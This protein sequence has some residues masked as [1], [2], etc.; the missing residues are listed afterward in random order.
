[1]FD[2]ILRSCR[3]F[4]PME[5]FT[6][7]KWLLCLLLLGVLAGC[8]KNQVL[9]DRPASLDVSY[10]ESGVYAMTVGYE[11]H[12]KDG[13]DT[14]ST[15][16]PQTDPTT[17]PHFLPYL[18][19]GNDS[20]VVLTFS[21]QPDKLLVEHYSAA[22][23][24]RNSEI[25]ELSGD[26]FPAPLDGGD[27]LYTVQAVW[28]EERGVKSWGTCTYSFRF[29]AD[30]EILSTA[31][32]MPTYDDLD[33]STL[34]TLEPSDLMG[35][36]FINNAQGTTK[37]CRTS[38]D[39]QAVVAYLGAN[40]RTDLI[41]MT[42]PAPEPEY[43]LRFVCMDGNQLTVGCGSFNGAPW[44]MVGGTIYEGTADLGLLWDGLETGSVSADGNVVGMEVL[45]TSETFPGE[46]WGNDFT[47]GYLTDLNS[48]IS[49]DG[50][51]LIEDAAEPNGYRLEAGWP[52]QSAPLAEDCQFWILEDHG[53]PYCRVSAVNLWKWAGSGDVLFCIY[54]KDGQVTAICEQF[55]P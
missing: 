25:V 32:P 31:Q 22:D 47:Y 4:I 43:M 8:G 37:T 41:P 54:T 20:S 15:T 7:K 5:G 40:L 36:E 12:R 45:E 19:A 53:L 6:M 10:G 34:L 38:G 42:V 51:R 33:L 1:M 17:N 23:G 30:G 46:D 11:W 55:L 50:M 9:T 49:Y 39:K 24:Y 29:L 48:E 28:L 13:R 27:H 14:V 2:H 16:A 35:I 3:D 26:R 52:D 44:I 21:R 18:N